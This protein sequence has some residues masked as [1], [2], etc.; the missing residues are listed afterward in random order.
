M[1]ISDD[2]IIDSLLDCIIN[3]QSRSWQFKWK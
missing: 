3:W 1:C 2:Y